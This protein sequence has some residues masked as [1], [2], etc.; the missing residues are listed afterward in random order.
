[1]RKAMALDLFSLK[2]RRGF[3]H[4]YSSFSE[5]LQRPN[6]INSKMKKVDIIES[7]CNFVKKRIELKV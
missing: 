2:T 6:I 3:K 4:A 5:N 7:I 1:M